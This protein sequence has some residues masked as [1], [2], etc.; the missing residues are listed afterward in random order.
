[1]E[2]EQK[3]FASL[4]FMYVGLLYVIVIVIVIVIIVASLISW[5]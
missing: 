1:M 3:D 5:W 4:F 2:D